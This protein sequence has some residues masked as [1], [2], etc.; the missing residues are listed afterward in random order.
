MKF[1]RNKVLIFLSISAILTFFV[2]CSKSA[3]SQETKK[4]TAKTVSKPK[5]KSQEE[6]NQELKNQ[7][8]QANFVEINGHTSELKNKKVFAVGKISVVDYQD[9]MD[10][11]PSFT[12]SQKESNGFGIYHI[13]NALN[14]KGLKDGDN[15]KIYGTIDGM[16]KDKMPKIIATI[17]E[18]Q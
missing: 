12:L 14:I 7:A 16:T 4:A 17:I 13:T 10:V 8:V 6:L 2:G 15:V 5:E 1:L 3:N 9:T 18:K 11:F